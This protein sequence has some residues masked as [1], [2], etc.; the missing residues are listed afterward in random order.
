MQFTCSITMPPQTHDNILWNYT[1]ILTDIKKTKTF[2]KSVSCSSNS[3]SSNSSVFIWC[4]P[5]S[6]D[7]RI[8]PIPSTIAHTP[9]LHLSR[10]MASSFFKPIFSVSP[11]TCF[12][13]VFFGRSRFLLPLTLRSRAILKTLSS[14]LLSIC[15]SVFQ[16]SFCQQLSDRTW[17]SP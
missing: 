3:S 2:V 15:P 6:R 8:H 7:G 5:L 4:C 9:S 13:Q 14:S 12:L 1:E 17:L 10:F 16:L 11:S